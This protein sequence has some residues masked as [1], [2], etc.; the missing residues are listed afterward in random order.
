MADSSNKQT[1]V[2]SNTKKKSVHPFMSTHSKMFF[3]LFSHL[4]DPFENVH[5]L[6][7]SVVLVSLS[8]D[9]VFERCMR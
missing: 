2:A 3:K 7:P 6:F 4:G 9:D 1:N 8:K 5:E